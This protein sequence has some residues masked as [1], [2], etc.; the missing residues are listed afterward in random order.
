MDID[1][2]KLPKVVDNASNS[3][4]TYPWYIQNDVEFS[5]SIL[6]WFVDDRRTV[7]CEREDEKR[8]LITVEVGDVGMVHS[9][10]QSKKGEK[11]VAK[12]V[13]QTRGPYVIISKASRY[14]QLQKIWETR[15]YY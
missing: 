10:V 6:A 11:I 12:L 9:K 13:Y 4:A 14:I 5:C 7:Y 8:H 15:G 2:A 1:L 3:V